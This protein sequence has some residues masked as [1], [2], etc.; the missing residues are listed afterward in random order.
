MLNGYTAV[1]F[2]AVIFSAAVFMGV[3][4]IGSDRIP[5]DVSVR[6]ESANSGTRAHHRGGIH[7]GK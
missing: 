7:Y 2:S 6:I 1:L 5:D 3:S 4:G